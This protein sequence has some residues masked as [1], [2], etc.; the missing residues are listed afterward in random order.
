MNSGYRP[1]SLATWAGRVIG[2][3]LV[4]IVVLGLAFLVKLL[5]LGLLA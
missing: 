5:V 4:L 1:T 2:V 3:L